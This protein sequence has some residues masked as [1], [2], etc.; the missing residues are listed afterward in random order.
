MRALVKLKPGPGNVELSDVVEPT[1]SEHQ[2]K[3]EV[4]WCGI[5]GTDLHVYHDTFRNFPPV[6]LGHEFYGS[7]VE[8]GRAVK[9]VSTT[10]K[11]AVLG[12]MTVTCGRCVYCRQGEFMFCPERR[13]MGHGVNGAFARY[14]VARP[15]QLFRLPDELPDTEGALIEPF[16]AAVHAV[17]DIAPLRLGDVALVS[18]PGPMGLMALKL[19]AAQGIKT[20]VAGTTVDELRL[21]MA[22]KLGAAVVVDVTKQNLAEVVKAETDGFGVDVAFECA[23]VGASVRS[24]LDTL[25][26]L[27]AYVQVG[28]FGKDIT[29]PFDRVAFKQLR[30][31]GSVGYNSATWD[32]TL[33][34]LAQGKV[35]LGD[36]ITH[37]LPLAEWKRGFEL[38]EQKESLKVLLQP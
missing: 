10:D 7:I 17:C 14:V 34:I 31:L 2:V 13:G 30:V 6:I 23:G 27:G 5:C 1:P 16:A 24:C 11:Y 9:N 26:P 25:R 35:R 38:C 21:E 15:E 20:I 18:G 29:V 33:E 28:H 8:T 32:H 36:F 19:L 3:L 22:L 4:A 12:A 37:K